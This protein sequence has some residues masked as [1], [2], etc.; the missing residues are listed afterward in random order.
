MDAIDQLKED[1]RQGRI[2]VDRLIAV[3]V[4]LQQQ[5]ESTH[6]QLESTQQQLEAA[7]RRIE[8]LEKK[9][10]GSS[11][12]T[13]QAFSMRAE[14]KRQEKRGGKKLKLSKKGR[15]G[16]LTTADKLQLAQSTEKC[17]PAGVPE[18]DCRFSHARP[19]WQLQDGRAVL[20]R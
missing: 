10:G 13:D 11:A 3:M 4:S 16:R 7:R 8:E 1:V 2:D 5:L 14:E 12:K 17:Y 9:I 20:V 6:Q 18:K 19:V 15:R